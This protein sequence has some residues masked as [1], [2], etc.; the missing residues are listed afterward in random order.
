MPETIPGTTQA[1][2]PLLLIVDGQE[3]SA[4]SLE[5]LLG[6]RGVA[7]VRAY[8]GRKALEMIRV[9]HPDAVVIDHH[10]PDMRGVECIRQI[11]REAGYRHGI[12]LIMLSGG[13]GSRQSR[14]E[15]LAAGA[16]DVVT[17]PVDVDALVLKLDSFIGA[18]READ[19]TLDL[20]LIDQRSNLYSARGL[21]RRS[22]E[23]GA[24]AARRKLP[25]AC[26]A[27][28]AHVEAASVVEEESALE[29]HIGIIVAEGC[30]AA[31]RACDVVGRLGPAEFAII[32]PGATERDAEQ[33]VARI[34]GRVN[35]TEVSVGEHP[36]RLRLVAGWAAVPDF[37]ASALDV[38]SLLLAASADAREREPRR[39]QV[40]L[41]GR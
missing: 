32:A 23:V 33:L 24:D 34:T 11:R 2:P 26:I 14:L 9:T 7:T 29:D 37:S 5:T 39:R 22:H 35:G 17:L 40:R 20:G 38:P 28:R 6:P 1:S 4:R 19:R 13:T 27:L 41:A 10:L 16:W 31:V 18:K 3:W 30:Q 12:P 15:A 36:G 8:T 25:I 21:V